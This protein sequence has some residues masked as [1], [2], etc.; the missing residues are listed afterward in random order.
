[1]YNETRGL[2][3]EA[4]RHKNMIY[5]K[6]H[7]S[8][9]IE[10]FKIELPKLENSY[11]WK[12]PIID[13]FPK[14]GEYGYSENVE[15]K[16]YFS[17]KWTSS[18]FDERLA[19]SKVIVSD[20]GG[21]RNNRIT[22]LEAYVREITNGTPAT[23]LKGVASY[24]KIY[25]IT[26]MNKYAIYDSRVAVCLNAIQWNYK[27]RKGIV[28]NYIPGRNNVTGHAG[29]KIGFAYNEHFK[30]ESLVRAGWKRVN[31]DE[32]YKVYIDTLNKCLHHFRDYSL[33]DLEMVLFANAEKEC[34]K[35]MES[36]SA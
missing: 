21:V 34:I 26:N 32:T 8:V 35:A 30:V 33:Y 12:I 15:L 1:M 10:Y 17:K 9:L 2:V 25:A 24:S 5:V 29:K 31:R 22:T 3:N 14:S 16:K 27:I 7:I 13:G 6:P 36:V 4:V 28:F 11:R 23:P 19:L 18:S 20:W